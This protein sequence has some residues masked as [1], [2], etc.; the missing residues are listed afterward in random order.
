MQ[1]ADVGCDASA[2][3][4]AIDER[5][6]ESRCGARFSAYDYLVL[7]NAAALVELVSWDSM[8]S[9]HGYN[10]YDRMRIED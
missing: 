9:Y 6:R 4:C 10:I 7:M 5:R 1:A 2:D 3:G 8:I